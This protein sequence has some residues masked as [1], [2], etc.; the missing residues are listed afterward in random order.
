MTIWK[1]R[2]VGG[3]PPRKV[4]A[5]TDPSIDVTA[6][7]SGGHHPIMTTEGETDWY[8]PDDA[9]AL[10]RAQDAVFDDPIAIVNELGPFNVQDMIKRIHEVNPPVTIDAKSQKKNSNYRAGNPIKV[11]LPLKDEF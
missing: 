4:K 11:P 2:P 3:I 6:T 1:K 5:I 7:H 8:N 9:T 10:A